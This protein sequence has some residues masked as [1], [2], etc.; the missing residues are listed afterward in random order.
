MFTRPS[1]ALSL[2][3]GE[4][5]EPL[6]TGIVG[7]AGIET[8]LTGADLAHPAELGLLIALSTFTFFLFADE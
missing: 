1:V 8:R 7:L 6:S 4:G 3:K 5:G 2:P